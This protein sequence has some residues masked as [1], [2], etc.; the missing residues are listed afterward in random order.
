MDYTG[1]WVMTKSGK[2][3]YVGFI[4]H[5]PKRAGNLYLYFFDT[6]ESRS[7]NPLK[8]TL[9]DKPIAD[10]LNAT[11]YQDIKECFDVNNS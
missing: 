3:G 11:Y 6:G 1:Q 5:D 2:Y 4:D 10:V 8:L 7:Y 9:V